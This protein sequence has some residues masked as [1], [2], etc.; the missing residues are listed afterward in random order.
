MDRIRILGFRVLTLL[1][2]FG[3]LLGVVLRALYSYTV[4]TIQ[5]LMMSGGSDQATPS[6]F[7]EF[8][9]VGGFG[10]SSAGRSFLN[11]AAC[12]NPSS[13]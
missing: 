10:A 8:T 5:L 13:T 6:E 9:F 4:N 7:L 1:S 3:P 12:P 11:G 2:T